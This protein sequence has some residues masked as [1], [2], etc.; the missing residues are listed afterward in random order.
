MIELSDMIFD[1]GKSDVDNFIIE[2]LALNEILS[3]IQPTHINCKGFVLVSCKS[4]ATKWHDT[5]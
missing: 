5:K 1:I 3:L 4:N 2:A